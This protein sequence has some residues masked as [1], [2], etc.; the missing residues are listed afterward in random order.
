[1]KINVFPYHLKYN[2]V[3]AIAHTSRSGTDNAFLLLEHQGH[4]GWG[5]VVFP[6]YYPETR[7]SYLEWV[8][9]VQIDEVPSNISSFI[10]QLLTQHP[11]HR[12]GIAAIDIALH[13]LKASLEEKSI[14]ALYGLTDIK[15]VSSYTIG[16]SSN[17]DISRKVDESDHFTTYYKLKV[18]QQNIGR[19]VEHFQKVST[20]PFVVDANQGFTDRSE[21][22]FWCSE[23]LKSGVEY[24]EQV[25]DKSDL[26]SHRWL[27]A[28]TEMCIIADESFQTLDDLDAIQTAFDG[29]NVKLMKCGGIANAVSCLKKAE[30]LGLKKVLGC[31]SESTVA[32]NAAWSIA[33]LADWADLDG[34]LLLSNDPFKEIRSTDHY[35]HLLMETPT[36]KV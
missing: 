5:E 11:T 6:P 1:M 33:S 34:P 35:I 32:S 14:A 21:A 4:V 13:N 36:N 22:L 29:V 28:Q 15:P 18:D 27:K 26:E 19:M 2:D 25:F 12:F 17:S 31:M 3:F 20:K 23:L 16:I 24:V 30:N 7:S 9:N 10:N 8:A